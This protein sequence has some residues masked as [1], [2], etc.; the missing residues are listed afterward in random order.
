[1]QKKSALKIEKVTAGSLGER[2]GVLPGDGL[3]TIN[4]HSIRDPIDYRF[5]GTDEVLTCTFLRDGKPRRV[6]FQSE[7][8]KDLGLVFEEMALRRC[9]NACLFC[10]VD[11]NPLGMRSS[12]YVKDED[13]RL[14]FLHGNYVTLT[15]MG[16]KDLKRIVEQRL[17]PLYVSVHA[18]D[19]DVRK[20]LLGL[21]RD[22]RLMDKIRF[23]VDH[24]I[25][26]HGQIVL[27]LGMNDGE[28][29]QQ[30]V[31]TLS[32]FFPMFRSVAVVPV[33]LTR[34]RQGLPALREVDAGLARR[35]LSEMG[36][37]QIRYRKTLGEPFVY[38]ADEFY[39][40]AGEALPAIRDYGDLWQVEN[41]VGLTR[42]FLTL[43]EEASK[44]FPKKLDR[45]RMFVIVTGVLAGP[46]LERHVLPVLRRITNL[47]VEVRVVSNR[48]YGAS[49]TV[50][51]LLTGQ[52][53]LAALRD[54]E[55]DATFLLPP[56]C[57]NVDGLFLDDLRPSDLSRTL[58]RPVL[59][60]EDFRDLF[61]D[62][63]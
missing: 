29:L 17:S 51:G 18:T 6:V 13:Y 1:M 2:F 43:F 52:D 39:L 3:L 60:L 19:P 38:L 25:E 23:L 55:D 57:L 5:Y 40:L 7:E 30:T 48:F 63:R 45:P 61:E 21:R 31:E 27:C 11:Q 36:A 53:I 12:L 59:I 15:R 35:V 47:E 16:R 46:V 28:V 49:V 32:A 9:G 8:G 44:N 37:F 50:S 34:H 62:G 22:D 26:L 33:G 56:N 41:G 24:R 20:R 58:N 10:F 14:S 54:E 42:A 4:G